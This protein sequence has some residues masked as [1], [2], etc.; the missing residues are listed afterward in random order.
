VP[1]KRIETAAKAKTAMAE[2]LCPVGL[3]AEEV[4]QKLA[5]IKAV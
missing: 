3:S 4:V 5:L 1:L 2:F